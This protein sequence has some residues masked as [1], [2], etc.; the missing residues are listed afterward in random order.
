MIDRACIS[1][2]NACNLRCKY[3]H[4]QDKMD[5]DES[6]SYENLKTIID[7]IHSY[8]TINNLTNFK[9]GIVGSGEPMIKKKLIINMLEYISSHNYNELNVYS[10]TNG[11][12][13]TEE[14][15]IVFYRYKEIIKLCFSLDGYESLHNVGRAAFSKTF[16]TVKLYNKIFGC[17]P[18]INATV[19]KISYQNKEKVIEFFKDLKIESVVFSKLVG[20]TEN[21]LYL[22]DE[23]FIDFLNFAK[24]MGYSSRQFNSI[25]KYDCTMYGNLC[26]VGR[27]NIFFTN[28]GV[29]PCGRFYKNKK[30][31]LGKTT[32]SLV[33]FENEMMKIIPVE[34]GLCYYQKNLEVNK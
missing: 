25:K 1:L 31:L 8:C 6:M 7:N 4:F 2:N 33:F 15:L 27:T 11:T 20:Y 13:L 19:N 3:C 30:Y 10:I 12:L 14:D 32:D 21:D 9:L 28:E 5:N 22:T 29:Y 18:S 17:M 26:G 24:S 34:D 16:N 23:E